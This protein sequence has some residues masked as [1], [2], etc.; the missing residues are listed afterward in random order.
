MIHSNNKQMPYTLL[1]YI[2]VSNNDPIVQVEGFYNSQQEAENTIPILKESI[3]NFSSTMNTMPHSWY[4]V[5]KCTTPSE[6]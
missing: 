4:E 1:R 6:W 5:H 3:Q 2:K